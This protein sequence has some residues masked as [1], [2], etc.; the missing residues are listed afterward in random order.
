MRTLKEK[1][2]CLCNVVATEVEK[3]KTTKCKISVSDNLSVLVIWIKALLT[4]SVVVQW[5]KAGGCRVG[6]E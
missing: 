2:T 6:P 4:F 3:A 1:M 5:L